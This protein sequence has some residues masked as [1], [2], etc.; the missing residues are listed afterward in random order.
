MGVCSSKETP[1]ASRDITQWKVDDGAAGGSSGNDADDKSAAEDGA[2]TAASRDVE[3]EI[4]A[5]NSIAYNAQCHGE[6]LC[7]TG[8][9]DG[10]IRSL[11][12]RSRRVTDSWKPHSRAVNRLVVG[13]RNVYSCSRDTTIAISTPDAQISAAT[14]ATWTVSKLCAHTLNVAAIA[15]NKEERALCSGGRDTQTIF[16]DLETTTAVTKNTTPQNVITCS[17]WTPNEPLVVQG[18]EDL[19]LKIW[20]QRTSLRCPAQT[21]RGYIYFA[22]AVDVSPDAN[23]ILTSSKGFNGVGGEVRV[24]D[25]RMGQQI[26]E[27]SGH[28]QD[29]TGCCFIDSAGHE[30]LTPVSVSKDGTVK[31]WDSTSGELLCERQ[32]RSSGMFTGVCRVGNTS[33]VLASTFG[34][35]VHAYSF[36][37]D[38]SEL[39]SLDPES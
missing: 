12:W 39:V 30:V 18:S 2:G 5:L 10:T 4:P 11:D 21:Y 19:S 8:W 7:L 6:E 32:E 29:A 24:W 25:R 20:D 9:E 35:Q 13:D 16:W 34:G 38:T 26:L 23:Y 22:L 1:R 17:K 33:T 15:V 37:G 36:S 27:F 14:D 3:V 31:M 28:Q